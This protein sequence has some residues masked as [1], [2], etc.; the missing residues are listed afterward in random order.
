MKYQFFYTLVL[1]IFMCYIEYKNHISGNRERGDSMKPIHWWIPLV[2]L[3]LVLLVAS[4]PH[5]DGM[6]T[7]DANL[8]D[9]YPVLKDAYAD[10]CNEYPTEQITAHDQFYIVTIKNL[11]G[12][13]QRYIMLCH[14]VDTPDVPA[15]GAVQFQAKMYILSP[16]SRENLF[17]DLCRL[18][19]RDY[20][21]SI[22]LGTGVILSDFVKFTHSQLMPTA[23]LSEDT[24]LFEDEA[25]ICD[26]VLTISTET[27]VISNLLSDAP[28][29]TVTTKFYFEYILSMLGKRLCVVGYPVSSDH[30]VNAE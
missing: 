22:E 10:L 3:I 17:T 14:L 25:I 18:K 6:Q 13:W 21:Q 15:E 20:Y 11:W 12:S 29:K 5:V 8:V 27:S 24:Y 9:S 7:V 16:W 28:A 2:A 23:Y 1:L 19:V 26:D 30:L 4:V